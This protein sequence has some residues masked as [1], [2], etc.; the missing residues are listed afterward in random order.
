[1]EYD[2]DTEVVVGTPA[3]ALHKHKAFRSAF[4]A[5]SPSGECVPSYRGCY[6]CRS[7]DMYEVAYLADHDICTLDA[8][9]VEALKRVGLDCF[10]DTNIR[11][12][13]VP[14][15]ALFY[16]KPDGDGGFTVDTER[17]VLDCLLKRYNVTRGQY[18][19]LRLG[20]DDAAEQIRPLYGELYNPRISDDSDG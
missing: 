5:V 4:L 15:G 19:E 18:R 1:M 7:E 20:V 16:V 8:E 14:R 12:A 11:F 13:V 2:P 9:H 6:C 10:W 17:F 3:S